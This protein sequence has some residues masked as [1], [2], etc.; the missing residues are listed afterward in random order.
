[1]RRVARTALLG[2]SIALSAAAC[3]GGDSGPG[4]ETTEGV[5]SATYEFTIPEGAGDALRAGTPLEILPAELVTTVGETIRIVNEDGTGHNV[6]PWFVPANTEINQS[7][8][9]P[10]TFEGV[11]TVHPSGELVLI[12]EEA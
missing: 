12:V 9:D 8:T 7:F 11:C 1:M 2:A 10:G 3:S 5:A 6:G 4:F